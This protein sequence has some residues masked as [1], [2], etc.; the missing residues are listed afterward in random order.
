MISFK[1]TGGL[2]ASL[3]G[4][5]LAA[6]GGGGGGGGNAPAVSVTFNAP[7]PGSLP[8]SSTASM[9]ASVAVRVLQ[10]GRHRQRHCDDLHAPGY[11][12]ESRRR[13]DHGDR[14]G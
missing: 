10:P 7:P 8:I 14:R 6:C 2:A 9:T 11:A 12:A 5:C 3:F 13:H 1:Q 4:L